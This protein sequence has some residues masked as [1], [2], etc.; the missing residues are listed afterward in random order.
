MTGTRDRGCTKVI[1]TRVDKAVAK[2]PE[3]LEQLKDQTR[4][5][6][7]LKEPP[8]AWTRVKTML[9]WSLGLVLATICFTG[10]MDVTTVSLDEGCQEILQT[11]TMEQQYTERPLIHYRDD[12]NPCMG[13]WTA[14]IWEA[15]MLRIQREKLTRTLNRI[16]T[17][18][19]NGGTK[20]QGKTME[21][22]LLFMIASGVV[23]QAMGHAGAGW[24]ASLMTLLAVVVQGQEESE[25][26]T[27]MLE[28]TGEDTGI[29]ELV[30]LEVPGPQINIHQA[31]TSTDK[32]RCKGKRLHKEEWNRSMLVM[33]KAE[34]S[35]LFLTAAGV[36]CRLGGTI[37]GMVSVSFHWHHWLW[38][39]SGVR[40]RQKM[41]R[42]IPKERGRPAKR[43][44]IWKPMIVMDHKIQKRIA[45]YNNVQK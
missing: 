26:W 33:K 10:T 24:C 19:E 25:P 23:C 35:L 37:N 21:R 13:N 8:R 9:N 27:P 14:M 4:K 32:S 6:D 11:E 36:V 20:K 38:D 2:H 18:Q 41:Y 42:C 12:W 31:M 16:A 28:M 39:S 34:L 15:D 17:S 5:T 1:T 22:I 3:E 7:S 43:N 45:F 40:R 44:I 29:G 30:N